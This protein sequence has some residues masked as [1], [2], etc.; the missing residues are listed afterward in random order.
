MRCERVLVSSVLTAAAVLMALAPTSAAPV[1]LR[2]GFV[3][4]GADTPFQF[5]APKGLA[6]H[7]GVTYSLEP[8]YFN[9][10]PTMVTALATGEIDLAPLAYSSFPLAVENAR[11]ED[12]RIIADVFQDGVPGYH[13]NEFMVLKDGPIKTVEDLKG[14]VVATNLA[15]SAVDIAMR[16]MLAQ[17]GLNPKADVT[18]IETPFPNMKAQLQEQ[19][20]SLIAGVLPFSEDP[21]LRSLARTLFTQQQALGRSQMIIMTARADVL[22]KNRAAIIDFLEDNLR[23]LRWFTDP[24][25]HDEA[26]KSL[27][28]YTKQPVER[29]QSWAFTKQDFYRDPTG[30]P[31]LAALQ[32]NIAL[33]HKIG[34]IP[35]ALDVQKYVDMSLVDA[36]AKRLK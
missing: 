21:A 29:F 33:T 27:A 20:V 8:I 6:Q 35:A 18:I 34:F 13:T 19:K 5:Y 22:A 17:R 30:R 23:E 36:A 2:I 14:K 9:G 31:D 1:K 32:A 7:E 16:A 10:T 15:G 26:V 28:A 11:M 3:V 4:P 12:L 24:A 25:H